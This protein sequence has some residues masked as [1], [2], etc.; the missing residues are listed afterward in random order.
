MRPTS[1]WLLL[2]AL[3]VFLLVACQQ[4]ADMQPLSLTAAA[5]EL[6]ALPETAPEP[7]A[8]GSSAAK[9]SL[10]KLLFWDPI[11]SGAR[12]VSCAS[13][14]HP[15]TGYADGL[16][17]PVG[18]SGVG[19]GAARHFPAG[20]TIPFGQRNTSTVLN[21]AFN[22]LTATGGCAPEAA[23]MFWDMRVQS[24][25]EQSLRPLVTLEEMQGSRFTPATAL[26]SVV[27]RLRRNARYQE[28]FAAAFPGSSPI[29]AGNLGKALA[30]FERT[31]VVTD[32]P[33]DRYLRGDKSALNAQQLQ[34]LTAF[35]QS[36]CAK[37]HSGPMF[38]D[39]KTHILGIADNARHTTSD[40]GQDGTYAFRTPSLRNLA[41]TAPYMHSGVLGTLPDVLRFYAPGRG[42]PRTSANP[43]VPTQSLD[44]LIPTRVDNPQAIVAFLLALSAGGFDTSIPAQVPSG[45]PV[46]GN[47]Q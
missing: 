8:N 41:A 39:F 30:C 43:H 6:S 42:G 5:A 25:E 40:S 1:T 34:G 18:T 9:R 46:G 13:C 37:C 33:V 22:G 4:E 11:L 2:L 7:A 23:P 24:L 26:D 15:A 28:L 31:L 20:T 47:I 36:G 32:T 16:D 14:H 19:Q 12:D 29:T 3:A 17:L 35:V 27:G 44:P 10:G 21:T 38:S 45:L